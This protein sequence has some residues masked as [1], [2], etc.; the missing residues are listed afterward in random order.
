M[1]LLLVLVRALLLLLLPDLS[2]SISSSCSL[3]GSQT[4]LSP[5]HP[6]APLE[7]VCLLGCGVS[8]GWGAVWNTCK[9]AKDSTA[10]VFGLG[11]VGLSV[12]EGLVV[13]GA[14]RII[15]VDINP[16][17]FELAKKWGATDCLNPLEIEEG[18][19]SKI[20][21][22]TKV[23]GDKLDPGGVDY[24]FECIG[25]VQVMRQAFECT[26]KGWGESCVIGVAASGKVIETR[27]FNVVIG[28]VWRGTAF[29]GWK[30]GKDVP[31]L[32]DRYMKGELKLDDYIT[33]NM[34]FDQINEAFEKL[35]S[36]EALRAVLTFD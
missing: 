19:V 26:H 14:K 33:H 22:M 2:A 24:S 36:G 5:P 11:A 34:K 4:L 17:K 27:P 13:A 9:V 1:V 23:P 7:K 10:A 18:I 20:I 25:N 28:R 6:S 35:H 15:A 31:V 8:T 30:S 21:N 32:C 12:I 16:A 29:G 3:N